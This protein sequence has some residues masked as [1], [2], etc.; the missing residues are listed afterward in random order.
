MQTYNIQDLKPGMPVVFV[1]QNL[2]DH[3]VCWVDTPH[4]TNADA[5]AGKTA[6]I[7]AVEPDKT[8][9]QVALC[10]KE[11]IPGGHSCDGRVPHGYG[12]YALAEH[13]YSPETFAEHQAAHKAVHEEQVKIDEMLKG[14][15]TP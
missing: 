12:A 13:L 3:P 6:L 8:G 10:F 14:F 2:N 15:V 9:K 11:K 7:V 5:L 1:D 4:E